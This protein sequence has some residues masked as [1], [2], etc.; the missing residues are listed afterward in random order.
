MIDT[1]V[2]PI[3][4]WYIVTLYSCWKVF[5]GV[6]ILLPHVVG[7]SS[8]CAGVPHKLQY[9][10]Y[11]KKLLCVIEL[12]VAKYTSYWAAYKIFNS[13]FNMTESHDIDIS[14]L[15]MLL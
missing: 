3:V 2:V 7:L 12:R 11:K 1:L 13:T 4:W 5:V 15:L 14:F 9:N 6:W 10:I 8:L